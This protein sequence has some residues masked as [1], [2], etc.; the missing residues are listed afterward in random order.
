MKEEKESDFRAIYDASGRKQNKLLCG[1]N[2]L[3][4]TDDF[5]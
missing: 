3:L 5:T 4:M 1:V 2:V